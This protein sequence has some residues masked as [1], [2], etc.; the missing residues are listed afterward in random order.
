MST[1]LECDTSLC[2]HRSAI[3]GEVHIIW[4]DTPQ[5]VQVLRRHDDGRLRSVLAHLPS[6]WSTEAVRSDNA[7]VQI[8]ILKGSL[9]VSGE[10][11]N[12]N[13]FA[14]LAGSGKI[15]L[16]VIEPCDAIII[17]DEP[18]SNSASL[19]D[20]VIISDCFA[21]DPFVPVIEGK[22]LHGFERR[23]LWLNDET[24]ADTRLL[25]VPAGF[26]G[27]GPNWHPVNEEIFCIA[28]D[29][30]PDDTRPMRA[31]SYLYNPAHSIHGFSEKTDEG[32]ILLEWHDGLWDIVFAPEVEQPLGK[33]Q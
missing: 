16:E 9:Q 21:L 10:R 12:N 13:G 2:L 30:Q 17:I 4:N 5:E 27:G 31:G 3:P 8:F 7:L 20:P 11:L 26:T 19:T 29:I 25:K 18:D 33:A 6:G 1:E 32:C 23:V 15:Q 28:G 24:G 22:P 14:L